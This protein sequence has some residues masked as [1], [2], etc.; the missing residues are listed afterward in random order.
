MIGS[1]VTTVVTGGTRAERHDF[2][3]R[4][5]AATPTDEPRLVVTAPARL[6][7]SIVR[8]VAPTPSTIVVEAPGGCACCIGSVA[9][10]VFLTRQLR[11]C[12]PKRLILELVASDHTERIIAMLSDEWFSKVLTI[13]TIERLTSRA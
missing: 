9:F 1:V 8:S 11:L 3:Q 6:G 5:V 12:A 2:I 7:S 4:C 13:Q 10:R